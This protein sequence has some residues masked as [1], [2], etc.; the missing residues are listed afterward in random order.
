MQSSTTAANGWTQ[1]PSFM[2]AD[3]HTYIQ[4]IHTHSTDV[5]HTAVMYFPCLITATAGTTG[6]LVQ[7]VSNWD[8]LFRRASFCQDFNIKP[9]TVLGQVCECLSPTQD[10]PTAAALLF[11]VTFGYMMQSCDH[12]HNEIMY[13]SS[14][15]KDGCIL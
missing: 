12:H 4:Y 15:L 5:L 6:G 13:V 2:S 8:I 14:V 3:I 9:I 10:E 7:G 11:R 1:D